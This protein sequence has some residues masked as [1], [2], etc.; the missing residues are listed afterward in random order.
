MDEI[1]CLNVKMCN[2]SII[3]LDYCC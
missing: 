2:Y 3:C 1:M